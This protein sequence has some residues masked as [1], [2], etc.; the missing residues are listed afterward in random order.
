MP[1]WFSQWFSFGYG[2]EE[3]KR[4]RHAFCTIVISWLVVDLSPYLTGHL[5]G[6]TFKAH[7]ILAVSMA[8]TSVLKNLVMNNAD[9]TGVTKP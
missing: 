6:P 3:W 8:A 2:L 4:D 5:D 7:A 9:T 1:S